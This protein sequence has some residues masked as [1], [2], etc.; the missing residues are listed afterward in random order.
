MPPKST[1]VTRAK[2]TKAQKVSV[3]ESSSEEQTIKSS[4]KKQVESVNSDSDSDSTTDSEDDKPKKALENDD[5]DY[6]SSSSDSDD[7]NTKQKEKKAKETF[8]QLITSLEELRTSIKQV[9]S[10]ITSLDKQLKVKEKSRSA[11][12][13]Q[14]NIILKGLTKCHS[15]EV[16]KARKEKPK[17]KGNING[18][19]NKEHPVPEVLRN[20]LGLAEGASMSRP[21]VMSALNN[22]FTELKLKNGQN[23]TI[24][25]STARALGLG[26][27]D[28]GRVIKFVEFQSFLA[29][30]YPKKTVVI[31]NENE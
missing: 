23:T 1:N 6:E 17:R 25:K 22:K 27:E 10:E 16:N 2:T 24:D 5:S 4:K 7:E 15:D 21:K 30:F 9:N 14:V 8:E 28:E 19:F 31:E 12:E 29:S 18:G 13:R 11:L 20:F 3:A 26:K